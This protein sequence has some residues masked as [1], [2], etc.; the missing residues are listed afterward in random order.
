MKKRW[1]SLGVLIAIT[2]SITACSSADNQYKQGNKLFAEGNYEEAEQYY[3]KAITTNPNRADF[4]INY[5]MTLIKLG[6]FNEAMEQF[7]RVYME[8]SIQIVRENNKKS[9]RGK[10]IAL[11]SMKKFNDA[12]QCFD[13]ALSMNELRELDMD[14]LYYKGS[15]QKELGLY[16]EAEET[17][18]TILTIDSENREALGSR[19]YLYYKLGNYEKSLEDYNKVISLEPNAINYYLGKYNL[20]KSQGKTEEANQVLEQVLNLEFKTPED[21]YH[22]AKVYLYKGDYDLALVS[23]KEA[24]NQGITEASYYLG[25]IYEI[26]KDYENALYYY[27]QHLNESDTIIV[28]VYNQIG[29]CYIKTGKY[30]EALNYIEKGLALQQVDTMQVLKKNEI[31][32][33]EKLGMFDIAYE[34]IKEYRIEYPEDKDAEKEEAFLKTRQIGNE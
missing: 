19:A 13:Q 31:V 21:N 14:I 26:K 27:I 1:Y 29:S 11:Y 23:L 3:K 28:T 12:I 32:A 20:L 8:K 34:K 9:L 16:T 33:Y 5:G 10:G 17:Y 15:A 25:D 22:L 2:I 6:K 18:T 24:Y 4:Y 30:K 7:D